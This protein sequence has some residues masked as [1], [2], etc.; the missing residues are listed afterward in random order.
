MADALIDLLVLVLVVAIV[1]GILVYIIK[2]AAPI[3]G[4]FTDLARLIVLGIAVVVIIVS[5]V[6]ILRSVT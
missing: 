5:A 6:P 2:A 4:A 1:A 3:L